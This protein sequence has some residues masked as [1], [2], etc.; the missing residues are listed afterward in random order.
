MAPLGRPMVDV[1]ATA[2]TYLCAGQVLDGIGGF[3]TYGKC[4]NA[5]VT[6]ARR[7]LPMGLAEGC[8][9]TRSVK[10]DEVITYQDVQLPPG[11]LSD[12]LRVEQDAMFFGK[13]TGAR[14][15]S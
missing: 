3:S 5:D 11:R 14:D 10:K 4:E 7:Y 13:L 15:A 2:K 8:R 1:V 6:H 9:L 12:R